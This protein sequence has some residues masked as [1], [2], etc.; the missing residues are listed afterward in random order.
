[1]EFPDR[2]TTT[3][4]L[5]A[6]LIALL[7]A[8]VYSARRIIL[9]FVFAV[10]FAYVINP[11]VRFM[12]R[13]SL[14]FGDLRGPAVVE[15]YFAA[16]ILFALLGYSVAPGVSRNATT[17]LNELPAFVDG[18]STG[19]IAGQL[20]GKYGWTEEQELRLRF[21]LAEHKDSIRNLVPAVDRYISNAAL[22]F[23]WLL[24]V[25]VLAIYF[26]RDGDHLVDVFIH[27]LFSPSR[28]PEAR[29]AA[30]ELHRLLSEYIR[31]QGFLCCL[32]FVFYCSA[33][34]L[35]R[36]PHAVALAVLGG[37]LEFIPVVGWVT[38]FAMIVSVGVLDHLHWIWIAALLAAWRVIQDYIV[39]PRIMGS[40]LKIHPLAAIF[41]VLV[42]AE[43]G[44]IAGIYLS[45]PVMASISLVWREY[46]GKRIMRGHH[47]HPGGAEKGLS[48]I[49]EAAPV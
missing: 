37:L 42:G 1:M 47:R 32:S 39:S 16:V 4:L 3:V 5:T 30:D 2:R 9:I 48:G 27:L 22:V 34:L 12:Q 41:A 18:L 13:H 45:V 33:M 8:A 7:C 10:F 25:P 6:L 11:V 20:R 44:G 49:A 24:L 14:F 28:R 46:A 35:L 40:H 36:F 15:A 21:V 26:L 31:A 43:I 19:D 17:A 38:T 29:A 23:G